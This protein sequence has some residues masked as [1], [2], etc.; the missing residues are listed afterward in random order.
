M[1]SDEELQMAITAFLFLYDVSWV[2]DQQAL[3][4]VGIE[5]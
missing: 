2:R 3:V 1:S 4:A 5:P